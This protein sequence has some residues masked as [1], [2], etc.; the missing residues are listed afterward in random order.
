MGQIIKF[1][2]NATAYSDKSTA[3]TNINGLT[4]ITGQ[5]VI[6]LY[7]DGSVTKALFAIGTGDGVGKCN[8]YASQDDVNILTTWIN[9]VINGAKVSLDV[10]TGNLTLGGTL[11]VAGA[12]TLGA[13][14]VSSGVTTRASGGSA[15]NK[16]FATDGSI[17]TIPA[18]PNGFAKVMAENTSI[19]ADSITDTLTIKAGSNVT[20]TGDASSDTITIS[21]KDTV[22][23]HPS[24]TAYASGFYKLATDSTGH[25][26]ATTAVAKSDITALGIPAQ[27]TVY[28]HP[29]A[30]AYASGFYKIT[31]NNLGHVTGATAVTQAD[32]TGLGIPNI[33]HT[34]TTTQVTGLDSALSSKA[35]LAGSASQDFN[36]NNLTVN[37]ALT[38]KGNVT[39]SGSA[40]T[41]NSTT[42]TT[43]DNIIHLNTGESGNG[44]T[45]RYNG[46]T[47]DRGVNSGTPNAPYALVYDSTDSDVKIG[48]ASGVE[49]GTTWG[50]NFKSLVARDTAMTSGDFTYWDNSA[51]LLKTK[52]MAWSDIKSGI[53]SSFTPSAHNHASSEVTSMTGYAKAGGV[54]AITTSDSLNVAIGKLEKG[55]EGKEP[56]FAKNTAFNKS[57]G[58]AAGTVCDGA[59]ARL[60][61][62]RPASDVSAWAKESSLSVNSVPN[63]PSSKITTMSGYAIATTESV[64]GTGDTLNI[65]IG[66]LEKS[67]SGKSTSSHTHT[68]DSLTSKPT[69]IAEYGI[70]DAPTKTGSGASGSWGISVTGSAASCSGNSVTAT[71]LQTARTI[72]IGSKGLSFD[73][74]ANISFSVSEI[75][76]AASS[77][78][79]TMSQISGDIDGGTY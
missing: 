78:T 49:S 77:H 9:N 69:T 68:F 19:D 22:Y 33:G 59:D 47:I 27:D 61:N 10:T 36:T 14:S 71:K 21:S 67:L 72:T 5:P 76:A 17:G 26:T 75:G 41:V 23:T 1:L 25:V 46:I 54:S 43:K 52:A 32:I 73:G 2:R 11:S 24:A 20:I 28:T 45:K 15:S 70:T 62:S 38:V 18:I 30:T 60:S 55:L 58:N 35:A 42:V 16:Y 65:A 37:A 3:L 12:T 66:K 56:A 57:F 29:S 74:T 4:H 64:I 34:H 79:H 44:T 31:T 40:T 48:I 13:L 6:A 7:T 8:I 50:T 53:P 63:L 51:K 39:F